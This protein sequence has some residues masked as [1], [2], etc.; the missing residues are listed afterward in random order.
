MAMVTAGRLDRRSTAGGVADND[1]LCPSPSRIPPCHPLRRRPS[2]ARPL[3]PRRPTHHHPSITFL[4]SPATLATGC[5]LRPRCALRVACLVIAPLLTYVTGPVDFAIRL[6]CLVVPHRPP[7]AFP[8]PVE[9]TRRPLPTGPIRTPLVFFPAA[10]EHLS[11]VIQRATP[12]PSPTSSAQLPSLG[13]AV[14]ARARRH[15]LRQARRR[16]V[17]SRGGYETRLVLHYTRG[18]LSAQGRHHVSCTSCTRR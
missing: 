14:S 13:H 10:L 12:P 2:R 7:S 17:E 3:R 8:H 11:V 1:A 16:G 6:H 9:P 18:V 4:P 5:S 15:V